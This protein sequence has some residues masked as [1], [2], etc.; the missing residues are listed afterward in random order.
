MALSS[1]LRR[2]SLG[3]GFALLLL[4]FSLVL[5]RGL[6]TLPRPVE[7][8]PLPTQPDIGRGYAAQ[9]SALNGVNTQLGIILDGSALIDASEWAIQTQG[10]AAAITSPCFPKDGS[11]EL[12]VI[13][14]GDM[15]SRL[16]VG[17]VPIDGSNY[18]AIAA[19]IQAIPKMGGLTPLAC[20]L[21]RLADTWAATSVVPESR[22]PTADSG[23][24]TFP[25]LAYA[26]E[27]GAAVGA[28]GQQHTYFGYGFSLPTT[29]I[30]Q[31][32]EVR[33]D[34]QRSL[35]ATGYISVELSWDG[36]T[37][38]TTTG[39]GTGPLARTENTYILGGPSNLWGRAS[40][41]AAEVN[42]L[43]VRVHAT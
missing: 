29:A 22:S 11:I 23:A 18:L 28:N 33:V 38:W 17:P 6:I 34:A 37:N 36:G 32:I 41:T 35:N 40:W 2:L 39:Y 7:A 27:L 15:G 42:Q 12:T 19:Q 8:A 10:L 43:R 14:I 30:V 5:L 25:A 9:A 16:E 1:S 21:Y 4:L 13:Q 3:G 24:W 26:N 31:G 20:G